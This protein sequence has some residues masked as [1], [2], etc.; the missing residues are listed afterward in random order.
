[1]D[2]HP[3]RV[4]LLIDPYGF[5]ARDFH[6]LPLS[7]V[8][9]QLSKWCKPNILRLAK[10]LGYIICLAERLSLWIKERC[11]RC[12]GGVGSRAFFTITPE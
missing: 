12:N 3:E 6:G 5:Q 4:G 10:R 7:S 2:L 11:G 9:P 1:V 8:L